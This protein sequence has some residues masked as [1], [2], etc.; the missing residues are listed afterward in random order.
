[1]VKSTKM[2]Y[3]VKLLAETN[4]KKKDLVGVKVQNTFIDDS[5]QE[6]PNLSIMSV[7]GIEDSE[8]IVTFMPE[9]K[10]VDQLQN[11]ADLLKASNAGELVEKADLTPPESDDEEE[12]MAL[13]PERYEMKLGFFITMDEPVETSSITLEGT[14]FTSVSILKSIGFT[15]DLVQITL[16]FKEHTSDSRTFFS[17]L[18]DRDLGKRSTKKIL[19]FLADGNSTGTRF[20][21][22]RLEAPDTTSDIYPISNAISMVSPEAS[23]SD[24]YLVNGSDS[25]LVFDQG[26]VK[27]CKITKNMNKEY[28]MTVDVGK[29]FLHFYLKY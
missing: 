10:Q 11:L 25:A 26:K 16:L 13:T 7:P 28:T 19:N 6:L 27:Q 23:D 21:M 14:K 3:V 5:L 22:V 2:N 18:V 1:M 24:L 20:T 8:M 15:K 12:Y 29:S 17:D 4:N 9:N